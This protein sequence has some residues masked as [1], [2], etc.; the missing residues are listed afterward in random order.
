MAK[1]PNFSAGD[2]VTVDVS[3]RGLVIKP[4]NR[5]RE[6]LIYTESELLADLTPETAHTDELARITD[7]EF[8]D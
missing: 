4:V 8:G 7:L 6:P 1:V 5:R 2:P 3:E